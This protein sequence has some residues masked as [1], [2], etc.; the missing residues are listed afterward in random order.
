M[1]R[2][3]V[4]QI[5]VNISAHLHLSKETENEILAEIRTHL[6]DAVAAAISKGED[7]QTALNKAADQFAI[8]EA[9]TELQEIHANRESID[10]VAA[11]AIPVLLA[12]ILR[13]LAY[14]PDGTWQGWPELVTRPGFYIIAGL[15]LVLPF[16]CFRRWRYAM[17]SWGIFWFLTVIFVVFPNIKQ[18]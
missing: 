17:A 7:E 1:E 15:T 16:L 8:T 13:W 6:E 12:L 10:A 18:W 4:D 5:L 2:M 11:T 14:A 3:T 9:S